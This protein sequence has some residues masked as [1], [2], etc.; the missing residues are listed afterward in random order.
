VQ[1]DKQI[2]EDYR[3]DEEFNPNE[4]YQKFRV[5]D[6]YFVCCCNKSCFKGCFKSG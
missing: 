4:D 6:D 1:K 3:C 5:L 2:R